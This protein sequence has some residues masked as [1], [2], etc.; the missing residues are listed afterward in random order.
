VAN[1][2]RANSERQAYIALAHDRDLKC[3]LSHSAMMLGLT[4]TVKP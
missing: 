2:D 1:L 4:A 3:P